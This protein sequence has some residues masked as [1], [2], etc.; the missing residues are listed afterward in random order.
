M[1]IQDIKITKHYFDLK[2]KNAEKS[3]H[4]LSQ[5]SFLIDWCFPNPILPNGK[6]LC[7]LLVVFDETAIILQVKDLKLDD[8]GKYKDTEIQKNLR[9]LSGARR[10]IFD[11]KTP[12]KLKNSK[13]TIETFNPSHIKE[14]FLISVLFG[15]GEDLFQFIDYIKGYTAHVFNKNFTQIIFNELDTISD[16]TDYLRAKELLIKEK[17]IMIMGGEEELLAFYLMNNR[18][19]NR[20]E[21][22]TQLFFEEGS[23][24]QFTKSP[25]YE[26]KK[27]EDKYSY[28]WDDIINR[29]HEG[30]AKYEIV[31]R[32]LARPTRF[33]RRILGKSFLDAWITATEDIIHDSYRRIMPSD[34]VTYCFL[35]FDP[36]ISRESRIEM[37]K[38]VCYVARGNYKQNNK[39]LGIATEKYIKPTCSYDFCYLNFYDWTEENEKQVEK[40]QNQ[41]GI[42]KNPVI[43]KYDEDEYPKN[44]KC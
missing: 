40:L 37:L 39:V 27:N 24:E 21:K 42:L 29:A 18:S 23:W 4:E 44:L 22:A 19:F 2:G 8:N 13:R 32:E 25:E 20:I 35:F 31:A 9:Q 15:D 12:I 36:D 6:E 16:F 41:F 3:I 5:K 1:E 26:S 7:D 17:S 14:V 30:S 33:E 43:S 28:G 11:L 34:G 38:I 10:Q